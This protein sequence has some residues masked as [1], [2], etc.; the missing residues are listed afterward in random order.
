MQGSY[1][2]KNHPTKL[3]YGWS[4]PRQVAT[5]FRKIAKLVFVGSETLQCVY[6]VL[7]VLNVIPREVA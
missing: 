2:P 4:V 3:V 5:Y 7:V 6:E 1:E